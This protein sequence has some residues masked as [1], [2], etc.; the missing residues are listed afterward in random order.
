[1]RK[2]NEIMFRHKLYLNKISKQSIEEK[3]SGTLTTYTKARVKI[4]Y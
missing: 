4:I 3:I 2:V 1:M